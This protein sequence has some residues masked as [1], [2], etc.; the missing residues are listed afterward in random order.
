MAGLKKIATN[1]YTLNVDCL[2]AVWFGTWLEPMR[3]FGNKVFNFVHA[4]NPNIKVRISYDEF[5]AMSADNLINICLKSED[6]GDKVFDNF[7]Q[8]RFG[9]SINPFLMGILHEIGHVM[10][11]DKYLDKDRSILYYMLQLN[12][13][14]QRIIEYSE[15]YFQIPSEFEATKWA[16]NYYLSHKEF[17]DNF[18]KEIGYAA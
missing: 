11:Y 15:M 17:C 3:E 10:T 12:Y 7:I 5:Y 14:E 1:E 9:I 6:F 18:L 2:G 4:I 8:K 13:D 16:V